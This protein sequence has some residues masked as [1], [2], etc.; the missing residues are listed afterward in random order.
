MTVAAHMR[1]RISFLQVLQLIILT[2]RKSNCISQDSVAEDNR[3]KHWN[4]KW[5]FNVCCLIQC[6]R[7]RHRCYSTGLR[8]CTFGHRLPGVSFLLDLHNE[9]EIISNQSFGRNKRQHHN[10][11]WWDF[12]NDSGSIISEHYCWFRL[13]TTACWWKMFPE[14]QPRFQNGLN[15][16]SRWLLWRNMEEKLPMSPL[17]WITVSCKS[18]N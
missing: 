2:R 3:W 10:M 9:M 6:L 5:C 13:Q 17:L 7:H 12:A 11:L 16:L 14:T 15:F 1:H 4:L 8:F 18:R